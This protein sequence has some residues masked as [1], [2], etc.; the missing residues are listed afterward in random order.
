MQT[1][2]QPGDVLSQAEV[3]PGACLSGAAGA[4]ER[5]MTT[6]GGCHGGGGE[7]PPCSLYNGSQI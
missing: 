7:G 6:I 2:W 1:D 4:Y 3:W 5:I